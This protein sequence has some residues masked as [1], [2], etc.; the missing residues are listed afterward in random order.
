MVSGS[1]A[2]RLAWNET[3][4]DG[5]NVDVA[6]TFDNPIDVY[7]NGIEALGREFKLLIREKCFNDIDMNGYTSVVPNSSKEDFI[8]L[9]KEQID[10]GYP[11]I[12]L[13]FIGPP[14]ACLI[15]GYRDDGKT[16]L[17]W[18]F[19][20][21]FPE[22]SNG[23]KIDDSGYFIS[24]SWWENKD[25]IAII[26]IGE[27][28]SETI[29]L[30]KLIQNAI[31]VMSG[32]RNGGNAKGLLAYDAW[33]RA[34]TDESQF[35]QNP[36]LPLIME[37]LMCQGDAMDC[38]SDGRGNAV[39]YFKKLSET[40]PE[41]P[42]FNKIAEKFQTVVD[43]TWSMSKI[44]GGWQRDEKQLY[45]LAETK[46]RLKIAELI[47]KCKSADAEALKLLKELEQSL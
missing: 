2:F 26:S 27:K 7:K 1:T 34:I 3:C 39:K 19:F 30:K 36:V 17:G 29:S 31:M 43:Y 23:I 41:Q 22:Y 14:E 44:L 42:L 11:C 8:K 16:L 15:T 12:G 20:Q 28:I 13:G 45:A 9:I 6:N 47:D 21:S 37:R 24:S 35:P 5:G 32:H 25:T 18:N 38:L 40:H 10:K 33:K 46:N 4:W